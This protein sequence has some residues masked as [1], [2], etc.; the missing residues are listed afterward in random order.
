MNGAQHTSYEYARRLVEAG[1]VPGRGR[2]GTALD[3]TMAESV[4]STI[5]TEWIKRH[6]WKTRLH[7]ELALVVYI[8]WYNA[9]WGA[10]EK[11][12]HLSC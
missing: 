11:L 8:G 7:L 3:N 9:H 2:T 6:T 5:K 10:V 4:I 12:Y 1:I